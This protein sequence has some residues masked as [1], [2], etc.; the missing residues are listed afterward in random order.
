M[1]L[2]VLRFCFRDFWRERRYRLI[3]VAVLSLALAATLFILV[4]VSNEL[5]YDRYAPRYRDLYRLSYAYQRGDYSSHF[6][7]SATDW[8][9]YLKD[10]FPEI[11]EVVRLAPMRHASVR[12]GEN[13]FYTNRFFNA[14]SC[15]FRVFGL[16]LVRG[17]P[18]RVLSRPESVVVS[19][20][21]AAKYFGKADPV[22]KTIYAAHQFDT[23]Q[24]PYTVTGVMKDT[25]VASHVHFDILGSFRDPSKHVGWSYNYVL[26]HDGATAEEVLGKFPEFLKERGPEDASE[27]YTAQLQPVS[28]I[29]LHSQK[30]REIES[31][32]RALYVTIF[33]MVAFL[34]L[35]IAFI[36]YANLELVAFN[37]KLKF[38]YMNRIAGARIRDVARFNATESCLTLWASVLVSV[39]LLAAGLP[40]FNRM[41]GSG[42][43]LD[44]AVIWWRVALSGFLFVMTGVLLTSLPFLVLRTKERILAL[45][46]DIFYD[47]GFSVAGDKKGPGLRFVPVIMQF[48]I[49]VLLVFTTLI[50]TLQVRFMMAA[51][52][53]AG[54]TS[55]LVLGN[56]SRMVVDRYSLFK[57][58]L[59]KDPLVREVSACMEEPSRDVMDAMEYEMTGRKQIP[60]EN[61]LNVMPCDQ[62]YLK[63]FGVKLLAGKHFPEYRGVDAPEH[64]IINETA[65]K[66]MGFTDPK[67]AIGQPFKLIFTGVKIFNGGVIGGV[68]R[69]FHFYSLAG[70]VKPLVMFQKPIWFDCFLVR[71]D[72]RRM[73]EGMEYVGETWERLFPGTPFEYHFTDELY[74]NLYRNEIAQS[75]VLT[76]FTVLTILIACMG[77]AGLVSYLAETRTKELGIRKVHGA[78]IPDILILLGKSFMLWI[79]LAVLVAIPLSLDLTGRLWLRNFVYR[80]D[81]PWWI[82]PVTGILVLLLVSSVI[83]ARALK[84]AAANPSDSLRYE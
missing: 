71:V 41:F 46:G 68:C 65:L 4:W 83:T 40:L 79:F 31:N 43:A 36:N 11:E 76:A 56:V 50:I 39:L 66:K 63:F 44:R 75:K 78:R 61:Y 49:S 80:T 67:E 54:D 48:L 18:D 25:P 15:V 58:K 29:H 17:D 51:G 74:G 45:S 9:L 59:L 27:H 72:E 33:I 35:I 53:G 6:A 26:L 57:E 84:T 42:L 73:E 55:I 21:I 16:D 62:D 2:L 12:M 20:T 64:Y 47:K 30:D 13:K 70:P 34:L 52:I 3:S 77:L 5:N 7:R 38:I 32:G 19:E 82:F 22:G 69:D 14:D 37:R 81:L 24:H 10:Y 28:E 23:I 60:G 8:V 1:F